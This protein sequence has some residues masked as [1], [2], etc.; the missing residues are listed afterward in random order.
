MCISILSLLLLLFPLKKS[1][2]VSGLCD[3]VVGSERGQL[4]ARYAERCLNHF[5]IIDGKE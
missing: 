2:E 5:I 4:P 3:G 1:N